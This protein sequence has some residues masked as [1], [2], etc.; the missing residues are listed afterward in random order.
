LPARRVREV[1]DSRKLSEFGMRGILG[2]WDNLQV[3][4]IRELDQVSHGPRIAFSWLLRHSFVIRLPRR[5]LFS[6]RSAAKQGHLSL[7]HSFAD[8]VSTA[9]S[10]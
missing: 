3:E 1:L 2:P 6:C 9:R 5:S 7:C 4:S 10:A 8:F